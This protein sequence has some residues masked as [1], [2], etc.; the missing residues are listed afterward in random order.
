MANLA[1]RA[2]ILRVRTKLACKFRISFVTNNRAGNSAEKPCM[3][4]WR[5]GGASEQRAGFMAETLQD[6]TAF[7]VQ[8]G[9]RYCP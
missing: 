4:A 5:G 9:K 1:P 7:F 6:E 3:Y 2:G 8:S